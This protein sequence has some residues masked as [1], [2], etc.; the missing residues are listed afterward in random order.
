M[1]WRSTTSAVGGPL[2]TGLGTCTIPAQ[3]GGTINWNCLLDWNGQIAWANATTGASLAH[4]ST[5]G[6]LAAHWAGP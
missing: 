2:E 5:W 4:A 3:S 6:E 1:V